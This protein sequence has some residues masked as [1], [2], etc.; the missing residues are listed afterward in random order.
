[1][2]TWNSFIDKHWNSLY[3]PKIR[4]WEKRQKTNVNFNSIDI[5]TE[6]KIKTNI[7]TT[8]KNA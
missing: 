1:M 4:T 8:F 2:D 6:Y 7:F 5:I 3:A